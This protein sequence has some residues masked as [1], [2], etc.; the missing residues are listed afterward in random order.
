MTC[1]PQAARTGLV[2]SAS[3]GGSS[4]LYCVGTVQFSRLLDSSTGIPVGGPFQSARFIGLPQWAYQRSRAAAL[5]FV[6]P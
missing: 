3:S 4:C 6:C 2:D 1:R 5:E